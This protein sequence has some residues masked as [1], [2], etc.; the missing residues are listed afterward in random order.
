MDELAV[1][2]LLFLVGMSLETRIKVS[3]LRECF[4]THVRD[5]NLL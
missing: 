5:N 3:K 2:L 1:G 4:D